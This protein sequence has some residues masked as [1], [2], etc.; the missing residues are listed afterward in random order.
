MGHET[1]IDVDALTACSLSFR[2]QV[3]CDLPGQLRKAGDFA[4]A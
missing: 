4:L 1:G 3:G 2:E